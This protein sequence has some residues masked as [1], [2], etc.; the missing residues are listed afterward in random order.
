MTCHARLRGEITKWDYYNSN[1]SQKS[2]QDG[3]GTINIENGNEKR[4]TE[5]LE[6]TGERQQMAGEGVQKYKNT[7]TT[8][9]KTKSG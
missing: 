8:G 6:G 2:Q 5:C 7:S 1:T 3:L 9:K 4:I